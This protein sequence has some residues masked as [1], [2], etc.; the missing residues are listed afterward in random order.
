MRFV[1]VLS[2]LAGLTLAG[3]NENS[4]EIREVQVAEPDRVP[5]PPP[6]RILGARAACCSPDVG[7]G[8]CVERH[9]LF[10]TSQDFS[11]GSLRWLRISLWAAR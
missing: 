8:G 9:L 3:S 4:N 2:A 6:S 5:L 11:G 1:F 10:P 7:T